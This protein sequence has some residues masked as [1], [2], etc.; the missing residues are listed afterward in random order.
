MAN[1]CSKC[2]QLRR[3]KQK[4][5]MI[6]QTAQCE[7]SGITCDNQRLQCQRK[8]SIRRSCSGRL[9]SWKLQQQRRHTDRMKKK[10]THT[11]QSLAKSETAKHLEKFRQEDPMSDRLSVLKDSE[12]W[13]DWKHQ[14]LY[15]TQK[16]D[17][18]CCL[19]WHAV[20]EWYGQ[21]KFLAATREVNSH[22]IHILRN[23]ISLS[24]LQ[25]IPNHM[26][27][28]ANRYLLTNPVSSKSSSRVS[29]PW[30][31]ASESETK[32]DKLQ[33]RIIPKGSAVFHARGQP[34]DNT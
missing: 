3:G 10:H 12:N 32:P 16:H 26:N 8:K 22:F 31:K 4:N 33:R 15:N 14:E 23:K 5:S 13:T 21:A 17:H 19:A 11:M 20:N 29:Q 27:E 25:T 1:L 28:L 30:P 24:L 6:T 34:M 18:H 9:W 2:R 7:W